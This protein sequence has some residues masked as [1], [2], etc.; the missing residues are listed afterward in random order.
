MAGH[1]RTADAEPQLGMSPVLDSRLEL[2]ASPS[3]GTAK[4]RFGW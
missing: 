2:A 3:T 1:R 4:G